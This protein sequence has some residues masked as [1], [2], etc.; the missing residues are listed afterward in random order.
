MN[1]VFVIQQLSASVNV[2]LDMILF[3]ELFGICQISDVSR[4]LKVSCQIEE[5][6]MESHIL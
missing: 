3:L 1:M 5:V 4:F 2:I 6:Y